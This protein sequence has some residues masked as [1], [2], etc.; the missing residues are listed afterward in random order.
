[1]G[2]HSA[3]QCQK[4]AFELR[5]Y[6]KMITPTIGEFWSARASACF[7]NSDT[8]FWHCWQ[9]PPF[10]SDSEMETDPAPSGAGRLLHRA[11]SEE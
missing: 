1:M 6:I 8:F 4:V 7:F 2:D 10:S 5:E 3:F 9:K 11:S